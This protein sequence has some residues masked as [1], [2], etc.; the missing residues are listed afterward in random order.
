MKIKIENFGLVSDFEFDTQSPIHLIV[1]TN[2]IGKSYALTAYYI[3]ISSLMEC[4]SGL[5]EIFKEL[6]IFKDEIG[7]DISLENKL[8]ESLTKNPTKAIDIEEIFTS[9]IIKIL[10][11]TLADVFNEKIL[12]SYLNFNSLLSQESPESGCSITFTFNEVSFTLTSTGDR[13]FVSKL[14]YKAKIVSTPSTENPKKKKGVIAIKRSSEDPDICIESIY[15]HS[16]AFIL[17]S[18]M[19]S[20]SS[21][22]GI[23]YLPA[24]RS[25]LYQALSSF[26]P[27][28]AELTKKRSL[29]TA[30]LELPGISSQLSDYYIKLTEI[31]EQLLVNSAD[32]FF[33]KITSKIEQDILQGAIT[34]DS[35][36]KKL[37]FAPNGTSLKLDLSATSSMV[38]E[39]GPVIAYLRYILSQPPKTNKK[40]EKYQRKPIKN[41]PPTKSILIVEEPEA[42]LHPENQI[43]ITEIYA[44]LSNHNVN[45]IL[46]SH[47]NYIFNK[48]SNLI[49]AKTISYESVRCD[50]FEKI[51]S[52]TTSTSL[53]VSE[54][55]I[56]DRNF[57]DASE[58]LINEKMELLS[59]MEIFN[60]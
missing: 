19:M 21:I 34:Y 28:I 32:Q 26:G 50:I 46:T 18:I 44:A 20:T 31:N 52:K 54:F 47:S 53:E 55:G 6:D 7:F 41:P 49:I 1:G 22:S 4:R 8:R 35:T 60:D 57:I 30:K 5:I 42:H 38:S 24:S 39:L 23:Y 9:N 48:L 27:I 58:S 15:K 11:N 40:I 17:A 56:E 14:K 51:S 43:K 16:S 33:E 29:F 45:V 10:N 37:F 12:S 2:N 36:T 59:N 13:F 25:G 3:S